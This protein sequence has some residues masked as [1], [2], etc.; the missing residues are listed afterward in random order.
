MTGMFL[1]LPTSL[2]LP[3]HSLTVVLVLFLIGSCLSLLKIMYAGFDALVAQ[4]VVVII[5]DI[6]APEQ[7]YLTI[8]ISKLPLFPYAGADA[9]VMVCGI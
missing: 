7:L 9:R 3:D 6:V 4:V 2:F 5:P 1:L 8:F